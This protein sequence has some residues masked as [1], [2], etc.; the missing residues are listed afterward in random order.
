KD[1]KLPIVVCNMFKKG[2]LL[3]VTKH[4]QGVF[5]MVK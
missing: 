2:N 1:N 3:Q 4:Q 5:S